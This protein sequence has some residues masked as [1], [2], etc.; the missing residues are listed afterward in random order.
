MSKNIKYQAIYFLLFL[1]FVNNCSYAQVD[2]LKALLLLKCK[3]LALASN[4]DSKKKL[5]KKK[6]DQDEAKKQKEKDQP[7]THIPAKFFKKF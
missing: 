1:F 6:K 3:L 2:L 4:L 5:E 7:I